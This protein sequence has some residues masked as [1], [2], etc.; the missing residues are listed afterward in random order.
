[1]LERYKRK[2][3]SIVDLAMIGA[4]VSNV[5]TVEIEKNLYYVKVKDKRYF[6]T[7]SS[8][9]FCKRFKILS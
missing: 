2:A 8:E 7:F 9:E 6:H 5:V 4:K 3:I 1:M